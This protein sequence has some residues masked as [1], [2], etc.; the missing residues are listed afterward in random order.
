MTTFLRG[1]V[2]MIEGKG[3]GNKRVN[4]VNLS[5]TNR[6]MKNLKLL[7]NA[8]GIDHSVLARKILLLCLEDEMIVN[9]LQER[10]CTQ[11]AYKVVF[12][13]NNGEVHYTLTGR[14]DL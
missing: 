13:R 7:A 12:L 5:L 6:E 14:E 10:Y 8:C 9:K 2:F 3:L 1:V 4:R 11:R